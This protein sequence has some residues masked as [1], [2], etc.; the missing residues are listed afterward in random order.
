MA[1]T[2]CLLGTGHL[3]PEESMKLIYRARERGLTRISCLCTREWHA[4]LFPSMSNV[5]LRL[6]EASV[7]SDVTSPQPIVAAS[8]Q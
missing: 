3:S 6:G 7:L 5:I 2:T 8:R 4:T 1:P